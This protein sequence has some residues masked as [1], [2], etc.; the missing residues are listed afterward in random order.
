MARPRAASGKKAAR[1]VQRGAGSSSA[2]PGKR[3][4]GGGPG[5]GGGRPVK[6][7]RRE[8]K[9]VKDSD[10]FEAEDSDPDEVKN[11]SRYD[12]SEGRD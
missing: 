9:T 4:H 10:L 2:G 7:S 6:Q 5:G 12:V 3:K 8:P 1:Q 11:A